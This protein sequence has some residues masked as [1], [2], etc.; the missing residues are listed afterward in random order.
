M[1]QLWR[2]ISDIWSVWVVVPASVSPC[3]FP[4]PWCPEPSSVSSEPPHFP[5][6]LLDAL[7]Q[8]PCW[9]PCWAWPSTRD[10][11]SC[12]ST[13]WPS[14]TTLRWYSEAA[15][16]FFF[17]LLCWGTRWTFP[18]RFSLV[19]GVVHMT[20]CRPRA[21]VKH[22]LMDADVDFLPERAEETV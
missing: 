18:L 5:A 2:N 1:E 20:D 8:I 11:S 9:S 4:S 22:E 6:F 10:T 3:G 17:G 19:R 13:S 7:P 14:C 16:L 15:L 12:R 21:S